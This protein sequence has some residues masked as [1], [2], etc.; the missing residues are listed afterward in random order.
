MEIFYYNTS[1]SDDLETR[2][3]TINSIV[4]S[5]T[6]N[7][8]ESAERINEGVDNL[9]NRLGSIRN[10]PVLFFIHST[11]LDASDACERLKNKG[12]IWSKNSFVIFYSGGGHPNT[13]EKFL[14]QAKCLYARFPDDVSP[15][16]FYYEQMIAAVQAAAQNDIEAF[17]TIDINNPPNAKLV[18]TWMAFDVLIQGASLLLQKGEPVPDDW[19]DEIRGYLEKDGTWEPSDP[20]KKSQKT[21]FDETMFEKLRLTIVGQNNYAEYMTSESLANAHDDFVKYMGVLCSG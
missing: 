19:F 17:A 8:V 9:I 15:G 7:L 21:Q 1:A 2:V 6:N 5:A 4:S 3:E 20:G 13:P 16:T 12:Q 18:E 10:D 11:D 14:P